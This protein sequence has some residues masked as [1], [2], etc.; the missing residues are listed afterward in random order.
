MKISLP[1]RHRHLWHSRCSSWCRGHQRVISLHWCLH[2]AWSN[3]SLSW[4][5]IPSVCRNC[6]WS[7][8]K[9]TLSRGWSFSHHSHWCRLRPSSWCWSLTTKYG[10][11]LTESRRS[12]RST[13][14]C[15]GNLTAGSQIPTILSWSCSFHTWGSFGSVPF[16]RYSWSF[17]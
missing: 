13:N 17:S 3:W 2:K 16:C 8:T 9:S 7:C 12:R 4:F 10:L 5:L 14:T 6:A 15:T 11:R 1:I